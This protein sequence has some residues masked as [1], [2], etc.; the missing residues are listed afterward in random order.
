MSDNLQGYFSNDSNDN[1]RKKHKKFLNIETE[2]DILDNT[3]SKKH[4]MKDSKTLP[5][6]KTTD[7]LDIYS[8]NDNKQ[9]IPI[10]EYRTKF[11]TIENNTIGK[12]NDIK[13]SSKKKVEKKVNRN[14]KLL[15]IIKERMKEQKYK[16]MFEEQKIKYEKNE[17]NEDNENININENNLSNKNEIKQKK[18][19]REQKDNK[20]N[21]VNRS[22]ST[23]D[24]EKKNKLLNIISSKKYNKFQRRENEKE[25]IEKDKPDT[26]KEKGTMYK[27]I[28][29]VQRDRLKNIIKPKSIINDQQN[30]NNILNKDDSNSK[31]GTFKIL[32]LLKMKKKEQN[33]SIVNKEINNKKFQ[34]FSI[35]NIKEIKKIKTN[36]KIID[37]YS[38]R[39]K[40]TIIEKVKKDKNLE[41]SLPKKSFRD[42]ED[43]DNEKKY[44][45]NNMT[46]QQFRNYKTININKNPKNKELY[47]KIN[48]NNK[49]NNNKVPIPIKRNS[50]NN[51]N[52]RN[53][54]N[55]N[56]IK[57]NNNIKNKFGNKINNNEID[58][59]NRLLNSTYQKNNKNFRTIDNS[60]DIKNN[61]IP[62]IKK[63]FNK[64]QTN[65]K[66]Y[67]P[68]I[69]SNNNSPKKKNLYY[70]ERNTI[71]TENDIRNNWINNN[72]TNYTK[73]NKKPKTYIKKS[74]KRYDNKN[75]SVYNKTIENDKIYNIKNK[76]LI[77]GYKNKSNFNKSYN[78]LN[79]KQKQEINPYNTINSNKN[80]YK[81]SQIN[82]R[83][84]NYFYNNINNKNKMKNTKGKLLQKQNNN[85]SML[86]N[87]ED[88]LVLEE[89]LND[90]IYSLETNDNIENKCF[91]FWNYY[92]NCSLYN[93]LDK[94][95][96]NKEDSN[97]VRLSIN[98]E[99]ISIMV[100]YEYSFEIDPN[101]QDIYLLLLELMDLNHNNLIIICEYI[102]TKIIP[103]NKPNIWVLKL[104]QIIKNS[105]LSDNIIIQNNNSQSS[106]ENISFNINLIIKTLKNILLNYP[107]EYSD[108]LI[109]LLKKIDTKTYEEINDFFR[110]YI[111]RVDNFE[112]SIIASSYL[113]KNKFF[114][115]LP[116]PYLISPPTKPYTLILD[117]DETLVHFQIKSNNGGTLRARPYLFGFLEEMGHYFELVVWTSATEAYANSLIDALEYEK[118]YFD[119]IL[120]REHAI[121]IGDD[122]V[123]D[124]TRVG[125]GLNRIIII[126]DMPQNFRL[127]R[128]NGITIK[129]FF[130]DD[131]DDSALYE[132]VPILKHIAEEGN[133]V[134]IGLEKY[135]EEIVKRITSNISRHNL[136]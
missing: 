63:M 90:I 19:Q 45:Y 33:E 92:F 64:N 44:D 56:L 29:A 22:N 4:E 102:L 89:R 55:S 97:I 120:Y 41:N 87:I 61:K 126:D 111:L 84:D 3:N 37:S 80:T 7:I 100:C 85:N 6:I 62:I 91:N 58:K 1:I 43:Y 77:E 20:E 69:I 105:K 130:G 114:K 24:E 108:I 8:N 123:K 59:N 2:E 88:L 94:I 65:N 31:K 39:P 40:K 76:R 101:E 11:N 95:F 109:S 46:Q 129:P 51:S 66:I 38:Y 53:Y 23:K 117:L 30:N 71:N 36:H 16:N 15:K 122:F 99:L 17:N 34:K 25:N 10:L 48:N 12:D 47:T 52:I 110:E 9:E 28:D 21:R 27:S 82:N 93:L 86:L 73:F 135:R 132:L 67:K 70:Y 131:L 128:E 124:L 18:E 113:K 79:M 81:E 98:Y 78:S 50:F 60:Y 83:T 96:K 134:R 104:Q 103:E 54:Q 127:Q 49:N 35:K 125:R 121:I 107:T 72:Y 74:P 119:Y 116:A 5:N 57:G 106:I 75:E 32:E 68:K 136:Y 26:N 42:E 118:K 133:D 115:P 14:L 112:G 13:N